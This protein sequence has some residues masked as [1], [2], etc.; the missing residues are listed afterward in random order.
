M[1]G[2]RRTLVLFAVASLLFGGTFVA[3]KAGLA[4]F[5]PL[6]FVAFRFDV[7]ALALIAYVVATRSRHELVPRTRD[8]IV[9]ILA[10]GVLSIGLTNALLFVGQQHTTSAVGAIVFS[11][12]PILTPVF[13]AVLLADERL[14]KR[15]GA[16]MV[17]GLLGVGLVVS[18]DPANLLAGGVGKAVLF[19]GAVSGALGSV[20]IR[21]ADGGLDSSVR[22]AWGLPFGAALSHL[23]SVA[24]GESPAAVT[25]SG[26][27]LVALGYVGLAAG[28]VAYIAYFDLL[29]TAGPIRANL[30]FYVV[31]VVATLGGWALLAEAIAPTAVAGFLTIFAGFAVLGSESVDLAAIRQRLTGETGQSVHEEATNGF[32]SGSG[33]D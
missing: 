11:L 20:L 25:W 21:W 33:S 3:A 24:A 22:T 30:V 28:A 16:G 13:A 15:G 2:S 9:G 31:P 19:A 18:P 7:A 26:E 6:L 5:P 14:S 32:G 23:L 4:Y 10:T 17:L 1:T 8:D 29:D 27:A 12:N